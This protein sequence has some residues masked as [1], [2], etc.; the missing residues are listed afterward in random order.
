MCACV[1]MLDNECKRFKFLDFILFF[2]N[3]NA[4]VIQIIKL[5]VEINIKWRGLSNAKRDLFFFV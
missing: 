5:F 1:R 2:T 4:N 3:I